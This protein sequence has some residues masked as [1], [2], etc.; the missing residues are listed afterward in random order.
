MAFTIDAMAEDEPQAPGTHTRTI[1]LFLLK[2]D[3]SQ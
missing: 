2:R 3:V 1:S